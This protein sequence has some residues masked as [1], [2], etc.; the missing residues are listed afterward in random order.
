MSGL[1][2]NA[3]VL[4][5]VVFAAWVAWCAAGI[6]QVKLEDARRGVP[7][8]E[9]RGSTSLPIIPLLPLAVWGVALL[10]D[11]AADPWGTWVVGSIHATWLAVNMGFVARDT[12]R[13][14]A[15]EVRN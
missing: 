14:R 3:L 5:A 9:R 13:L 1:P 10:I 2:M 8:A 7:K 12:R 6:A 11:L 4:L 15:L